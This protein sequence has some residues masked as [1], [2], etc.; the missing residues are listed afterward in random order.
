MAKVKIDLKDNPAILIGGLVFVFVVLFA[1][2]YFVGQRQEVDHAEAKLRP[3]KKFRA[4]AGTERENAQALTSSQRSAEESK[5]SGSQKIWGSLERA[6][7]KKVLTRTERS[8]KEAMESDT[9]EEGIRS[10][11]NRLNAIEGNEQKSMVYAALGVMYRA[12]DPPMLDEAEKAL[13]LAWRYAET[14]SEKT[15]AVYF[16]AAHDMSQG[17]YQGILEAIERIDG[18]SLPSSSHSLELG[19]MMGI[20]YEQL[21]HFEDAKASYQGIMEQARLVGLDRNDDVANVYRQAGMNLAM[22]LRKEGNER[23]AQTL[24][25]QVRAD[26]A[27]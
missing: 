22:I 2:A 8:V 21:G 18:E 15:E 4:K 7:K 5:G 16:Q 24:A 12:L 13:D 3:V 23:E 11:L 20:A 1:G 17:D 19:V 25:R 9:P 14:T 6:D 27:F 26:L 10:L